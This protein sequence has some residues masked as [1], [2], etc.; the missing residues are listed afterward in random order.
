MCKV[1]IFFKISNK[2]TKKITLYAVLYTFS[3]KLLYFESKKLWIFKDSGI[4][5]NY[6]VDHL[7]LPGAKREITF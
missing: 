1:T 7:A 5:S 3:C 2:K 6:S 4:L